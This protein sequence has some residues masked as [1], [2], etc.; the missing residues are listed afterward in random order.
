[1]PKK[2]E[3]TVD[4]V[5]TIYHYYTATIEVEVEDDFNEGDVESF[6]REM[7]ERDEID[8]ETDVNKMLMDD[9]EWE[10]DV[11]YITPF[12]DEEED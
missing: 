1:M 9:N 4:A 12:K 11:H 7:A 8:W 2:Y 3:V 6:V 5:E 10:Y